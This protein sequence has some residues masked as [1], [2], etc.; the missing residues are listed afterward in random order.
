MYHIAPKIPIY[1]MTRSN[2]RECS[3]SFRL[4]PGCVY[5]VQC[6]AISL[7]VYLYFVNW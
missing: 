2:F 4:C 5:V 3:L 7:L 6:S 1:D